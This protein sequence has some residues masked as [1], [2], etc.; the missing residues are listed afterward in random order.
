MVESKVINPAFYV[1]TGPMM[2]SKTT[3][4]IALV[5]RFSHKGLKVLAFKPRLDNRYSQGEIC[6]HN[7]GK[8]PAFNVSSGDAILE[9]V[10]AQ[11]ARPDVIAVD[12]AFMIDGSGEALISLY[13]SGFTVVVASIEM[14][15]SC[16][17]FPEIKDILPWAT[18]VEKCSA[19]C[20]ACGSDAYFTARKVEALEEI[21]IGGSELY[22]PRCWAHHSHVQ[23]F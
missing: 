11:D 2:G 14:S 4:L 13:R 8:I 9:I 12:E 6:T 23:D 22:E 10:T 20:T 21:A 7:G 19:V 3:R 15:S 1:F 18:H 5:D 17:V 16:N